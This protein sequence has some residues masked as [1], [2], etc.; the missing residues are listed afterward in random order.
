MLA[1]PVFT[2]TQHLVPTH[3]FED[4]PELDVLII[5]GG[6]DY[7]DPGQPGT[8]QPNPATVDSI[9]KFIKQ[10]YPKLQYL[11]TVCTG[12]GIAGRT[13]VL[14]GKRVTAFKGAFSAM[15]QWRPEAQWMHSAWWV[16]EGNI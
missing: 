4:L 5:P 10:R 12:A 13:G 7:F 11:I 8:G 15:K 9:V 16:E 3:T 14:D 2:T 1:M 6:M